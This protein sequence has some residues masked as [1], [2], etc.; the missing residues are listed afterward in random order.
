MTFSS[1]VVIPAY[2]VEATVNTLIGAVSDMYAAQGHDTHSSQ[3]FVEG[4]KE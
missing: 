1:Q 4:H 2:A 3:L